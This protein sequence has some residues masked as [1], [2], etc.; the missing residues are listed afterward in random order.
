[1]NIA[2]LSSI[3][4]NAGG[5]CYAVQ[6]L[7][8]A[9][10]RYE[11]E[12]HIF[13]VRD[14]F[15]HEDMPA[16][17][18]LKV[19]LY[20]AIG[21]L[22][23]S[24]RLR[25]LL[26]SLD[27]DIVHLHGLWKDQQWA[28]LQW[29]KRTKKPVIISP[30]GMLDPWALRNSAWKKRIVEKLF[31]RD[32][33]DRATCIH[34]LCRSEVDA[35]RAYGLRNPIALIPNGVNLPEIHAA[36][37]EPRTPNR[38]KQ[39]L[40]LGRIHPKKGLAELISGWAQAGLSEWELLIAGP[41]DG[42]HERGLKKQVNTFRVGDSV[43]FLGPLYGAEKD[44]LLRRA[45]AFILPS[46]SEGLP[47]SVLEAWSYGLPAVISEFCNLPEGFDHGAALR[48]EPGV[49]SITRG[50]LEL[51]AMSEAELSEMGAE[52]RALVEKRFT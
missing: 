18:P 38:K 42:G 21:P 19:E 46:F 37:P 51:G 27:A 32:A 36:T 45:D 39:L 22:S 40:F 52:G 8:K 6:Y 13:S 28:S 7:S 26:A 34:A 49:E 30:H 12:P 31:A 4:R 16:W 9:L 48:I 17:N 14:G 35:I 33:L 3:S 41:D 5:V 25:K 2:V 29:Q 43:S 11:C 15:S 20:R 24:A 1:M 50:L 44:R 10:A 23:S 47:M